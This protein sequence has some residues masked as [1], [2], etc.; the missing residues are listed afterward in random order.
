MHVVII[1]R[2]IRIQKKER[3]YTFHFKGQLYG[4]RVKQIKYQSPIETVSFERNADYLLW[5]Q[6]I[7]LDADGVLEIAV[8]KDKKLML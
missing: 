3:I 4:H 2:C 6:T 1:T 7:Q 8:L 5:A